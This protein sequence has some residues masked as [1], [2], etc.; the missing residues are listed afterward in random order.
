MSQNIN[1]VGASIYANLKGAASHMAEWWKHM[2]PVDLIT[3][4]TPVILCI[5]SRKHNGVAY[6]VI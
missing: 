5:F 3:H 1:K 2:I 4:K 6:A